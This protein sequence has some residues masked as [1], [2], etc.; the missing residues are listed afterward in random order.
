MKTHPAG[1]EVP[2]GTHKGCRKT[3]HPGFPHTPPIRHRFPA[4]I[5]L[6][7]EGRSGCDSECAEK[8]CFPSLDRVS[9]G[10]G[11]SRKRL[12]CLGLG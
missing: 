6:D 3:S 12:F 8:I 10:E 7:L 4:T 1:T 5:Q 2:S 9:I 11:N